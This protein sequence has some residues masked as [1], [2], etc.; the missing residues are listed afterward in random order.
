MSTHLRLH[1]QLD[2]YQLQGGS[3]NWTPPKF[4]KYR[5][6]CKLAEISLSVS[7]YKGILYLENFRGVQ[8]KELP[9]IYLHSLSHDKPIIYLIYHCLNE[10]DIAWN[11]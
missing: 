7:S 9:C 6:P 2:I 10:I 5:I 11:I 4:F 8:L 1:T 3:F